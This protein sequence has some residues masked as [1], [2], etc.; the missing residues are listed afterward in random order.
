MFFMDIVIIIR[1][2]YDSTN[3]TNGGLTV[4]AADVR[5]YIAI[6]D[7]NVAGHLSGRPHGDR[8]KV[9]VMLL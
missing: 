9:T 5:R 7:N 2:E 6:I 4:D 1:N 8:S 3:A